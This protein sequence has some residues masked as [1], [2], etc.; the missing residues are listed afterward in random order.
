MEK[1]SGVSNLS[2][3]GLQYF[4]NGKKL[5]TAYCSNCH[6]AQ[7]TG[8]GRLIPPLAQSDY[9]LDDLKRAAVIIKYGQKGPIVV[10]DVAYNQPMPANP[11]LTHLEI[12]E[13]ITYITNSWGNSAEAMTIESVKEAL[14]SSEGYF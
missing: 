6:T 5:Y 10:N 1:E 12:A 2:G 9:L 11:K 7:G 13:I 4:T 14:K 3:K 8:L